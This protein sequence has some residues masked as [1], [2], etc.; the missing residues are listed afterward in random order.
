MRNKFLG[1]GEKGYHPIR[2]IMVC[3][4]GLR[5]AIR[6]DFSVSYKVLLSISTLVACFLLRQWIDFL[7]IMAA[8]ALMLIAE[9][10]NS[11]IEALC[12]F[13]ETHENH[14]IKVIKDIS[15]AAAGISILLWGTILIVELSRLWAVLCA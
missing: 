13:I 9:M 5:Y 4:S 7:L 10:F 14:K 1:T 6:Y 11:A 15:A 2:K 12:D 3:I 8:T